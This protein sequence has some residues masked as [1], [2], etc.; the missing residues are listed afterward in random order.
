MITMPARGR[1]S[2]A[3]KLR[4]TTNQSPGTKPHIAACTYASAPGI[5]AGS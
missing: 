1:S 5:S 2:E 4:S 3:M